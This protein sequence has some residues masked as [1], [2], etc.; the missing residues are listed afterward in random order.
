LGWHLNSA[1]RRWQKQLLGA[2]RSA[3]HSWQPIARHTPIPARRPAASLRSNPEAN[4]EAC[5]SEVSASAL[6][7]LPSA[8]PSVEGDSCKGGGGAE[9]DG[10][11]AEADGGGAEADGSGEDAEGGQQAAEPGVDDE[12]DGGEELPVDE[13]SRASLQVVGMAAHVHAG[14]GED[15]GASGEGGEE[16]EE[17]EEDLGEVDGGGE[18][19]TDATAADP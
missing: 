14:T 10:G 5:N 12:E 3:A 7:R 9:A 18:G 11:G 19:A 2:N 1:R 13:A 4:P 17:G 8:A 6:E 16:G 15:G